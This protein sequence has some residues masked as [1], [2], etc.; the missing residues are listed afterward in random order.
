MAYERDFRWPQVAGYKY[1]LTFTTIGSG[2]QV[3][4]RVLF[5]HSECSFGIADERDW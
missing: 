1:E 5:Q 2:I 4:Q 3:R